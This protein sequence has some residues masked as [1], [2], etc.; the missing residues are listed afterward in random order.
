MEI[1][2]ESEDALSREVWRFSLHTP[3]FGR[4]EAVNVLV[5]FYGRE[6]RAT[7][8]H[9]FVS[10]QHFRFSN[11]HRRKYDSGIDATAVPLPEDVIAEI[12][13]RIVVL[14]HPAAADRQGLV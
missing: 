11:W 14:V 4:K 2:R 3:S 7:K 12:K 1:V 5:E 10:D 9:K 13:S 6:K 8:R